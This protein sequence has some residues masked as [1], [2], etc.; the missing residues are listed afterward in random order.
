MRLRILTLA[1]LI[2]VAVRAEPI[3]LHGAAS[4]IESLIQPHKAEVEKATA[5]RS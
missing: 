3:R 1:A 4:V 5:S 2:G